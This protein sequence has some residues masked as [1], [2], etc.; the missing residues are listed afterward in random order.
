MRKRDRAGDAQRLLED[1][2]FLEA[3]QEIEKSLIERWRATSPDDFQIRD[4]V[5]HQIRGLEAFR[6]QLASFVLT[7]KL[8]ETRKDRQEE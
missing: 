5:Y 3:F 6:N 8:V 4:D 2:V 7:G 1:P